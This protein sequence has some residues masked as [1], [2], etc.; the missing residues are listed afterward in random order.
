LGFSIQAGKVDI[1]QNSKLDLLPFR[2]N[3]TF[4]AVDLDRMVNEDPK[5]LKLVMD[6]VF[7]MVARGHYKVGNW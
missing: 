2:R 7:D 4:S 5:L 3:I 1:Y 6:E